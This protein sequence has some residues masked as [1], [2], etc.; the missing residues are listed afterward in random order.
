[1]YAIPRVFDFIAEFD[2][3]PKIVS[4]ESRYGLIFRSDDAPG[5]LSHYNIFT[6]QPANNGV[7]LWTWNQDWVSRADLQ[8]PQGVFA[9][10]ESHHVRLEVKKN[11]VRIFLNGVFVGELQNNS[12][13][14][15][16]FLGL[17]IISGTAP[18]TVCFDNFTVYSIP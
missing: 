4:P 15:P 3:L 7:D 18:E 6:L 1:M 8:V 11:T 10:T 5:G 13:T 9:R 2:V 16:G 14:T 17:S 12:I